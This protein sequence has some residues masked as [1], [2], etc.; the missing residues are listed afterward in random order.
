MKVGD[1][2][3][4]CCSQTSGYVD[5]EV[6]IIVKIEELGPLFNVY[7]IVM[8]D[9]NEVPF[10]DTEFELLDGKRRLDNSDV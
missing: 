8:S 3:I 7:W 5:G 9:G 10:W 4:L 2:A 6:G 1:L